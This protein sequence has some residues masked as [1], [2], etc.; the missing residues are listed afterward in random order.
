LFAPS[1]S[2]LS[3]PSSSVYCCY[4][5]HST[6]DLIRAPTQSLA[7]SLPLLHVSPRLLAHPLSR[8]ILFQPI[9]PTGSTVDFQR[10]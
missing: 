10:T 1:P 6:F 5:N 3:S 8:P 2:P 4:L 7:L 9:R